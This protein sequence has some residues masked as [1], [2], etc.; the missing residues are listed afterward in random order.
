[1]HFLNDFIL[2]CTIVYLK[3]DCLLF[4]QS[5]KKD[6]ERMH[7]R[8]DAFTES[9]MFIGRVV[10]EVETSE[11]DDSATRAKFTHETVHFSAFSVAKE[12]AMTGACTPFP[13]PNTTLLIVFLV[14]PLSF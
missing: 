14:F 2:F 9:G 7:A 4:Y 8:S 13:L 12:A 10:L 5:I 6:N 11:W 3:A 1:V